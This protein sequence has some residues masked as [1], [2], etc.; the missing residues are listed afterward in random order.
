MTSF[1][2]A[3]CLGL[4]PVAA[5]L[6]LAGCTVGPDYHGA[7]QAAP[8][9]AQASAFN[10]APQGTVSTAP[11]A[12][13]W[14]LALN[15]SQL[16]ALID[17][18]L[19]NSP[20]L[21]AAEARLREARAGLAGQQSN[22]L[23][24]STADVGYLRSR[25]PD[26][27][28]FEGGSS[29][30]LSSG[31][32]PIGVYLAGFDA[33]WEVDIFGGTRRAIEA[34]SA[35]ADASQADLAD[36]HVQ[37]AAEIAQDYVSLRDEQQR[38][39]IGQESADLEARILTLTE[40]RRSRGVA[41]DLDVER[42]RSQVENTRAS[43]IPL[44]A[45]VAESLDE[46]AVLTG[47]EPGALDS[48]L[49]APK[50]LPSLPATVAVGDPAHLLRQRPDIRAAERRLASQNAQ[51]GEHI[52]DW[53]PKVTLFGDLSFSAS[54]PGHLLRK[55]NYT[56]LGA[57]YLQWNILDFGRTRAAVDQAKAGRDEAE[58]K[59]ESTV[60]GAL[61][62]A[63]VALSRYGHERQNAVSLR[64]VEDSATHAAVLTEQRYR[65]GTTTALDWLD[66][67]RTRYSAEQNRIQSDAQ[68]IKDYVALQKSLGLGWQTAD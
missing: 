22:E 63:D 46:L 40:Q 7:P 17:A 52:A 35:E 45:Q 60:L 54:D 55:S 37:L 20:D 65:A 41:S 31:G 50:A 48:E 61:K 34:A 2:T 32:G 14:W 68:L 39:A 64:E 27:S 36:A 3:R 19:K 18:A 53:F 23:P 16:N 26:L 21:H 59:Y 15:D 11:V 51:I 44:D 8:V 42:I 6:A 1:N 24:K 38:V 13:S 43:I 30:S 9:A 28:S 29:N 49:S 12:A 5:A 57:P 25:S 4:L 62:D 67:E 47:R 56:W 66:T 10:R 33:S 58:A